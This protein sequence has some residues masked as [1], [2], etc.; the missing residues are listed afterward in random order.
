MKQRFLSLMCC[1]LTG[2]LSVMA[3]TFSEQ[4][5]TYPVNVDGNKCVVSGFTPF[6]N[7]SD[8]K[9]F[10]N[11]L[12]WAIENVCPQLRDGITEV[13][14][15]AKSF[16]CDLVLSSPLGSG[17]IYYC[18]ATFRVAEGKL[19]YLISDIKVES[20][21]VIMK[22]VTPMEKLNPEKKP[23]HKETIEDFV[24]TESQMLN[25]L[26]DYV[27]TYQSEEVTHWNDIAISRPVKGMTQDECRMAFGK[28]ESVSESNGETQWMY[29]SSFYLFFK[30]GRVTTIIK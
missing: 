11:A 17:N 7:L 21:V 29:G 19:V 27:T 14:I 25:K 22:K 10:A 1:L 9:I 8:E 15:P 6:S 20:S 30:D 3:Q 28:P 23:A 24:K 13:K 18:K 12:L 26:F 16:S 4:G 5:N 2:T